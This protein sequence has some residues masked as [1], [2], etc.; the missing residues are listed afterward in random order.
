MQVTNKA[1][2]TEAMARL[3][4]IPLF[5]GLLNARLELEGFAVFLQGF[6]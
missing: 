2:P 1:M 6:P 4:A 3:G 5:V